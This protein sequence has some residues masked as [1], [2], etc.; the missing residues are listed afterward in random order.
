KSAARGRIVSPPRAM[1]STCSSPKGFGKYE[2]PVT[3]DSTAKSQT[4][5]L[6]CDSF[7]VDPYP[8]FAELRQRHP[9]YWSEQWQR[10]VLTRHDD[11][12]M[13][14]RDPRRFSSNVV[15][16]LGTPAE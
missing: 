6:R 3:T 9:L 2:N 8:T 11:I 14:P 15:P 1:P 13:V 10:W 7:F 12:A 4:I 16:R 5:D